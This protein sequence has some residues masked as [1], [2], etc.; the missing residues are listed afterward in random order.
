MNRIVLFIALSVPLII[1]SRRSLNKPGTHG[2]YRFLCW[3]CILWLLVSNYTF[4]FNNPFSFQQIISW[5]C[6]I[7]S[8]Y[9]VIAGALLIKRT[10]KPKPHR[11]DNT[12]YTFEE[13]T[14][15][16][17]KGIF[18]Y[19]RH[20]LYSSLIFL[21]WGIVLKNI[22]NA[23]LII[24]LLSTLFMYVSAIMDERECTKYFG[25]R[26]LEYMKKTKRFIP[27]IL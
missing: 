8:G 23:L 20:P 17:D 15:L 16:I 7:L 1:I 11:S 21:T 6:L 24:A 5:F 9:Y 27:F 12:L 25:G 2:F 26:Y 22:T 3:E 4:W 19:I 13:T 10:G 14:E 18:K